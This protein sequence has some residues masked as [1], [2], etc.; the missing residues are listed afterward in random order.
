V[1]SHEYLIRT[2]KNVSL[3]LLIS[4]GPVKNDQGELIG[5]IAVW[6]DITELKK[7]EEALRASEERLHALSFQLLSAQER[8]RSRIS[9]ELH[10]E[11]GQALAS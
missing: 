1:E 8:E 2:E 5:G 9:R 6:Q 7:T 11:L 4:A 3:H 10:D